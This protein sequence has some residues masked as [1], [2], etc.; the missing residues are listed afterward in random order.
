MNKHLAEDEAKGMTV[1]ERLYVAGLFDEFDKAVAQRDV[2]ELE[3]ILGSL[4][5]GSEN[6]KAIIKQVL[7]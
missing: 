1:N 2:A 7:K 3:R 6:I 4:Y 5:L